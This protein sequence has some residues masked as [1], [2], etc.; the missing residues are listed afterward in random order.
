VKTRKTKNTINTIT[1]KQLSRFGQKITGTGG[2]VS[3]QREGGTRVMITHQKTSNTSTN[4]VLSSRECLQKL[5]SRLLQ[6]KLQLSDKS[7]IQN[8]TLALSQGYSQIVTFNFN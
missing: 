3:F 7:Y 8:Q 5:N 4:H 6:L 1:Y 2:H